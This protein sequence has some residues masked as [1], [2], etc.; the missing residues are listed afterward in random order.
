MSIS[1]RGYRLDRL[2]LVALL[3]ASSAGT[4]SAQTQADPGVPEHRAIAADRPASLVSA[5]REELRRLDAAGVGPEKRRPDSLLNGALIGAAA[6]VTSGLL[7][8][9][10][11]EPWENCLDDAGPMLGI[12]AL[13]AAIGMG[14]DALIRERVPNAQPATA[15]AR[16]R[17]APVAGRR[18]GGLQ[19][20]V[21]F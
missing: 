6:G 4:L 18:A 17:V 11:T 8:C 9:R 5:G 13:G 3:S 19:I 10:A 20:A 14:I 15:A 7:L 2:F 16:V 21:V 12:G 1:V